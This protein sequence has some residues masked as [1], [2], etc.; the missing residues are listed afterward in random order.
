MGG[1]DLRGVLKSEMDLLK[2]ANEEISTSELAKRLNMNI[3]AVYAG[4]KELEEMGYVEIH[5]QKEE[6]YHLTSVG[7]GI[8]DVGFP[9]MEVLKIVKENPNVPI[10]QL[11]IPKEILSLGIGQAKRGCLL[12]I[13]R[14]LPKITNKGYGV[15][16]EGLPEDL[17]L[18]KIIKGEIEEIDPEIIKRLMDRGLISVKDRISRF[19]RV[20]PKGINS[21]LQEGGVNELTPRMLEDGGW[22]YVNF[23]EYDIGIEAPKVYPAKKQPYRQFLDMIKEKL[24]S[25]GFVETHGPLVE[26]SFWNFDALF[27]AQNHPAREVH[28]S[29][30]IKKPGKGSLPKED[31]VENVKKMHERGWRYDWDAEMASRL[32]ARS[33]GTALSARS[34]VGLNPPAKRFGIARVFRPDKLD[35]THLVEFNQVEGI[36]ADESLTFRNLLGILKMFAEEIAE[37]EEIAFF[38]SYYPFTEPSVDLMGY[39][40]GWI[41]LAGA[42]MFRPEVTEPFGVEVPVIA[43]GLGVDRLAMFKLGID[44]IRYLFADDLEWLRKRP[45]AYE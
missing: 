33:Q 16:K 19:V 21:D 3:Q 43:W 18:N 27:Q 28:D 30:T 14:G 6:E 4:V 44:D 45:I 8:I 2:K 12:T 15:L 40:D 17:V 29:Y 9:E 26:L 24:I 7:E 22:R 37:I 34:L 38:P 32:I 31:Y 36:I 20:T 35:K 1:I 11:D 5:A 13:D 23:R 42:G 39:K 41:E 10:N 25:L